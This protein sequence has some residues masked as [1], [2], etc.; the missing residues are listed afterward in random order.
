[1][2]PSQQQKK[3][4]YSITLFHSQLQKCAHAR[5]CTHTHTDPCKQNKTYIPGQ[6][7][8][9]ASTHCYRKTLQYMYLSFFFLYRQ[10]NSFKNFIQSIFRQ[11]LLYI[12]TI[13]LKTIPRTHTAIK[14][15]H[16]IFHIF[17]L[18]SLARNTTVVGYFFVS[19]HTHLYFQPVGCSLVVSRRTC[20]PGFVHNEQYA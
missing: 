9:E 2:L 18:S 19:T 8:P 14:L 1:L 10:V 13:S 11:L 6:K 15:L 12:R 7:H 4:C 17:I 3:R 16:N 5:T 20:T